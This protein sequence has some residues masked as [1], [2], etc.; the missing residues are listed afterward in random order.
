MSNQ[1]SNI[2]HKQRGYR[3][4]LQKNKETRSQHQDFKCRS[5]YDIAWFSADNQ[6]EFRTLFQKQMTKQ[7]AKQTTEKCQIAF[8]G[9]VYQEL[10]KSYME[11]LRVL[12]LQERQSMIQGKQRAFK[13]SFN[14]SLHSNH[15]KA[16]HRSRHERK[17]FRHQPR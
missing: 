15:A 6:Q 10:L 13:N 5:S 7:M 12:R 1:K 16:N 4:W 11:H 8:D 14:A 9:K 3:A 2:R 17:R